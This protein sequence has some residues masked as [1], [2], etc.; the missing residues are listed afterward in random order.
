MLG[1]EWIY[2]QKRA[3]IDD[4]VIFHMLAILTNNSTIFE[5]E[6]YPMS[7][8]LPPSTYSYKI[9]METSCIKC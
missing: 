6:I 5:V 7:N 4:A 8:M 1:W 9:Y 2:R 3:W